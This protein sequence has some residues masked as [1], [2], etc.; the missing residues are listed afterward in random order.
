MLGRMTQHF[1]PNSLAAREEDKI[2]LLVKQRRVF[3][4]SARDDRHVFEQKAFPY[5][6]FNN[7]A[8]C[9]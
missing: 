7:L 8:C 5:N 4:A 1:F 9:R 2:E 3:R 6:G